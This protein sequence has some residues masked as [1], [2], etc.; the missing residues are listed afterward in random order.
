MRGR[1]GIVYLCE[2]QSE[3]VIVE[4]R[5]TLIGRSDALSELFD[6]GGALSHQTRQRAVTG[7]SVPWAFLIRFS[8]VCSAA[9]PI[10]PWAGCWGRSSV[11]EVGAVVWEGCSGL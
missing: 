11:E 2:T 1:A 8:A 9:G 7:R 6:L 5:L 3:P 4:R 10:R